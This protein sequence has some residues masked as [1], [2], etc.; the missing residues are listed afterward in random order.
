MIPSTVVKQNMHMV[1]I[2]YIVML[3]KYKLSMVPV[4]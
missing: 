4:K 2:F 1:D 3:M